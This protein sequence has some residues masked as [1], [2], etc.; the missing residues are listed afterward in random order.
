MLGGEECFL[1]LLTDQEDC[2]KKREM[3]VQKMNFL[4]VGQNLASR[5]DSDPG[6]FAASVGSS[7]G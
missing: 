2:I 4:F 6:L 7:S 3:K 5:R 1:S